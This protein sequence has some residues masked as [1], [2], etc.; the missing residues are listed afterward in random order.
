MLSRAIMAVV[1]VGLA[2]VLAPS[3]VV[4]QDVWPSKPVRI[5]VPFAVG[6]S[7][8][9][10][11]RMAIEW[12]QTEI[13]GSTFVAENKAGAGGTIAA[14]ETSRSAPDGY[15]LLMLASAQGA[16]V[17]AVQ[18]VSYDPVKN[19]T[20]IKLIA[21][22]P[23]MLVANAELP[24]KTTQELIAYAKS[25]NGNFSYGSAG[26]GS[27]AHLSSALFFKKAG[28]EVSHVAYRGN[29][30]ALVDVI[31]GHIGMMFSTL[32]EAIAQEKNERVRM[33]AVT[34]NKRSPFMPN[35]PTVEE[36]GLKDFDLYTWNGLVGP[37]GLPKDIVQK[38]ETILIKK[39]KE[40]AGQERLKAL[41]LDADYGSG[42]D[43]G[44]VIK[45]DLPVWA[46]IV[47]IAGA[48]MQ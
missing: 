37:A 13:P 40:P 39:M 43:F 42:A 17:P 24:V 9:A 45:K 10:I 28:V 30:P 48:K 41:G 7:T 14:T 46:Q 38:I 19:F 3:R 2:G 4:A 11:T 26:Q 6:G 47:E 5:L 21:T 31:A 16:I 22:N 12:L 1:A 8:D 36:A 25:K 33:L 18:T 29:A 32:P 20:P 27:V 35:V 44:A 34:S 23:F 15:T